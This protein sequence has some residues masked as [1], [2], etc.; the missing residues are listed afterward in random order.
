M[1]TPP[2]ERRRSAPSALAPAHTSRQ[3]DPQGK[4]AL[5]EATVQAPPDQ[6]RPGTRLQGRQALYSTGPRHAGTV[7][8]ECSDCGVR[9]RTSLLTLGFRFLPLTAWLP[10]RRFPHFMHC[11][12]CGRHTWCRIGWNE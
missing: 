8:V 3:F 5:F 11:P 9:T 10:A 4:A 12:G 6:L 2:G 7:I 1:T